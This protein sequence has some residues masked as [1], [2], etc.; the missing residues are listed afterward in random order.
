MRRS[1]PRRPGARSV[2]KQVHLLSPPTQV[3][4]SSSSSPP[5]LLG[6][7]QKMSPTVAMD[8]L[9]LL[10]AACLQSST[11]VL[12]GP[13]LESELPISICCFRM[14]AIR[15]RGHPSPTT[16]SQAPCHLARGRLVNAASCS[17]AAS[18]L[19][20][21]RALPA[22]GRPGGGLRVWQP[23]RRHSTAARAAQADG[24]RVAAMAP[25]L[26]CSPPTACAA[27]D[28]RWS[29]CSC[30]ARRPGSSCRAAPRVRTADLAAVLHLARGWS[31][32][33]RAWPAWRRRSPAH[34]GEMRPA[35]GLDWTER[36]GAL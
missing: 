34:E 5:T 13:A 25:P 3:P 27:H 33:M 28:R 7:Q 26:A 10:A 22:L 29:S 18:D 6:V 12:P 20:C 21:S 8:L 32:G 23:W 2:P 19:S 36:T 35:R 16:T 11:D 4:T 14:V 31:G 9:G 17:C 1:P 24:P 30:A 15:G